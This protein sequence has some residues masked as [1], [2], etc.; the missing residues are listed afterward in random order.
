[1]TT[2]RLRP[3]LPVLFA[4]ACAGPAVAGDIRYFSFDPADEVTRRMTRGVTLEVEQGLLGG[5]FGG[6]QARGLYSTSARGSARLDHDGGSPVR[7]ALPDGA[8]EANV[9]RIAPE[10]DGRAL[11]RAL[12]PGSDEAWLVMGRLRLNTPLTVHAVGRT[13]DQPPRHCV[14]LNYTFR[15][16][17]AL[18]PGD[19]PE[20]NDSLAPRLGR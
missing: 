7:A 13:G 5:L 1:M 18:P 10:G 14:Q 3:L 16:E 2:A 20:S 8:R 4:A 12:C 19:G 17:W 6:L 11:G 15:G 9:Y